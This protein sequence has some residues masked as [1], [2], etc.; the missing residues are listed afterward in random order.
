MDRAATFAT[1]AP[2]EGVLD[3]CRRNEASAWREL[4]VD[5]ADRVWRFAERLGVAPADLP[6][7]LQEVFVVVFRRLPDFDGRAR[8]TTWLFGIAVRVVRG[9]RRS[10]WRRRVAR[11]VGWDPWGSD[12]AVPDPHEALE[13][14]ADAEDLAWILGQM[15]PKLREV[16][17]LY[18]IEEVDG[19]SIAEIVGCPVPTVRSRLRLAREEFQRLQRRRNLVTGG[20]P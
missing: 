2:E 3:R 5:H 19:P 14:S 11:L 18:E 4:Y 9:H 17:V 6:D 1:E 12:S 20:P 10:L 8:F 15:S 16:H 7:V 13:R